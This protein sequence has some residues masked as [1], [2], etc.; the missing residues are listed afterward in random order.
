TY[1]SDGAY[2]VMFVASNPCGS[3][4]AYLAINVTLGVD[5][6][7]GNSGQVLVYPNPASDKVIIS[8]EDATIS[9]VDVI[10][11]VGVV[12]WKDQPAPAKLQQ[13]T[14]DRLPTGMYILRIQTSRGVLNRQLNIVR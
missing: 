3:D 11:S 5:D 8:S 12:V 2:N 9:A 13:L 7:E 6:I 1:T 14:V 10:N 4:T